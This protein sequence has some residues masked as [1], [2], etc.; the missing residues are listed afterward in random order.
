MTSQKIDQIVQCFLSFIGIKTNAETTKRQIT[1]T[2]DIYAL[3]YVSS[4]L[5]NPQQHSSGAGINL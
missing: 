2:Q 3:I 5:Y 4:R 1:S